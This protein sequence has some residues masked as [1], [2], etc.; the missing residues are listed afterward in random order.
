MRA[1]VEK[2]LS[3]AA[4]LTKL[5]DVGHCD[6]AGQFEKLSRLLLWTD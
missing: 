4:L 2:S 3:L 5:F 6:Q 1:S